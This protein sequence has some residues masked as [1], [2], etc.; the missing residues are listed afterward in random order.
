MKKEEVFPKSGYETRKGKKWL[1]RQATSNKHKRKLLRSFDSKESMKETDNDSW[2]NY[3]VEQKTWKQCRKSRNTGEKN[4][5]DIA[6]LTQ[7][8]QE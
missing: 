4:Y 2:H 6:Q 7:G 1:A 3:F 5:E 8:I